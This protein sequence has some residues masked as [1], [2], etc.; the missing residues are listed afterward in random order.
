MAD[1]ESAHDRL[2]VGQWSADTQPIVGDVSINISPF[3]NLS[4]SKDFPPTN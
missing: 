3:K 1:G 2:I 4:V